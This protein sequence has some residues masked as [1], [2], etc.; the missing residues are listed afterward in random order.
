[1][2]EFDGLFIYFASEL[3]LVPVRFIKDFT[4]KNNSWR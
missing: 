1:M 3:G 2:W 4:L